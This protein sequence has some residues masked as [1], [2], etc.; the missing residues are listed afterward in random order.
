EETTRLYQAIKENQGPPRPS[1]DS[2]PPPADQSAPY[3]EPAVAADAAGS[4]SNE[5]SAPVL[6]EAVQNPDYPL[7]GRSGEWAALLEMYANIGEHGRVIV[8]EGEGGIGKTR[9][10]EEF[11]AYAAA[12]GAATITARCY[13][14][15]SGLAYSPF[16]A[17]LRQARGADTL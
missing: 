15:E 6:S 17:A 5:P 7:V 14:G 11:L 2:H 9:L 8:L 13:E 16:I 1:A 4:K 10:A 12:H 3:G